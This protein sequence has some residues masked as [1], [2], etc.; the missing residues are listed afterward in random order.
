MQLHTIVLSLVLITTIGLIAFTGLQSRGP[1]HATEL[2]FQP[3]ITKAE[4]YKAPSLFNR[5]PIIQ[6]PLWLA[7]H[8]QANKL[9]KGHIL[10]GQIS[11]PD[12]R[13]MLQFQSQSYNTLEKIPQ[14]PIQM[15][16]PSSDLIAG[17]DMTSDD[18]SS[19]QNSQISDSDKDDLT[20]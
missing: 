20:P 18:T 11:G 12:Y 3:N 13:L 14:S 17:D 16:S 1:S 19:V 10:F 15:A 4:T 7:H 6:R 2:F 9:G 5:S 8:P